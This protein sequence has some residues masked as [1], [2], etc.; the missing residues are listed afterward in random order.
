VGIFS[1]VFKQERW[2]V[3]DGFS[4]GNA[5][6]TLYAIGPEQDQYM[7]LIAP[8]WLHITLRYALFPAGWVVFSSSVQELKIPYQFRVSESNYCTVHTYVLVA[9]LVE[10][11]G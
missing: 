10:D 11:P 9:L 2:S 6:L 7:L 1:A 8:Y 3:T 5:T 4:E